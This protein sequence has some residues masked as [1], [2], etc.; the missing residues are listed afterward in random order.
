MLQDAARRHGEALARTENAPRRPRGGEN[1]GVQALEGVRALETDAAAARQAAQ[2][3]LAALEAAHRQELGGRDARATL[4]LAAARGEAR[5]RWTP[6]ARRPGSARRHA[7][8][9]GRGPRRRAQGGGAS[10]TARAAP[11]ERRPGAADRRGPRA[12]NPNRTR[13]RL[14][15]EGYFDA[16]GYGRLL[17]N[18]AG[19]RRRPSRARRGAGHPLSIADWGHPMR[20]NWES[21]AKAANVSHERSRRTA[22][23][24]LKPLGT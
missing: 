1:R 21:V 19:R 24:L 9:K 13:G 22:A 3:R 14:S 23:E 6:L 18:L 12:P 15:T 10:K 5:E 2:D 8:G 7:R 20:L 16:H 11:P 17:P 4:A